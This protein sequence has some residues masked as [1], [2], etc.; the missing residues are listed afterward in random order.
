[1]I[2]SKRLLPSFLL[3]YSLLPT[4]SSLHPLL[5]FKISPD[6][7]ISLS[8]IICSAFSFPS[9][10]WD[11]LE[12]LQPTSPLPKHLF[13]CFFPV[14]QSYQNR[15]LCIALLSPIGDP[16]PPTCRK[17]QKRDPPSSPSTPRVYPLHQAG[18]WSA[19]G[20][21]AG[22][23]AGAGV[24]PS[25]S[26]QPQFGL[27]QAP[28]TRIPGH[29]SLRR[30]AWLVNWNCAAIRN[31]PP[32]HQLQTLPV[33]PPHSA[34]LGQPLGFFYMNYALAVC[35]SLLTSWLPSPSASEPSSQSLNVLAIW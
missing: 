28:G 25:A 23:G 24:T 3:P 16:R 13:F 20:S 6:I 30:A 33:C 14:A 27:W 21:G 22:A 11:L 4:P 9:G 2:D 12:Y 34:M 18:S 1:M 32:R 19:A 31:L 5:P 7:Y 8:A 17:G 35:S 10:G 26:W 15:S 29:V